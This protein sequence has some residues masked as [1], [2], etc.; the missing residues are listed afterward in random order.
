MCTV[1]YA[2]LGNREAIP[3]KR[4]TQALTTRTTLSLPCLF[5]ENQQPSHFEYQ[6]SK[7]AYTPQMLFLEFRINY[8][9]AKEVSFFVGKTA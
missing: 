2:R 8:S 1:R 9:P 6:E 7:Q 3:G 4:G 5:L